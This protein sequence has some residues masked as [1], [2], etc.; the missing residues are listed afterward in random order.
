MKKILVLASLF[1]LSNAFGSTDSQVF[2]KALQSYEKV[3]AAFYSDNL[4]QAKKEA[5]ALEKELGN[6]K[7]EKV[8]KTLA[9]TMKKISGLQKE[10][11]IKQA[12][13]AFNIISQGL[14]VVLEKH[15]PNKK[16]AR[17]YCPMVEK[18]WIQNITESEKVMNP[19]AAKSMPHCG[20]KVAKKV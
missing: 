16:Y 9:F 5:L 20:A 13:K 12:H 7:D 19:Y 1:F 18:Y 17:Y 15:L 10:G 8:T 3:H 2:E 14:L 4:D 11:D 6:L